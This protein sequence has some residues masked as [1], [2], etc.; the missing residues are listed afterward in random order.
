MLSIISVWGWHQVCFNVSIFKLY[1]IVV[2]KGI[3]K[4]IYLW[5]YLL[6]KKELYLIPKRS[7]QFYPVAHQRHPEKLTHSEEWLLT[8]S[9]SSHITLP[10]VSYFKSSQRK[11]CSGNSLMLSRKPSLNSRILIGARIMA[12]FKPNKQ[13]NIIIN[14]SLVGMS[15]MLTQE[16]KLICCANRVLIKAKQCYFQTQMEMLM[17]VYAVEHF[18]LY[19]FGSKFRIIT[20]Y[21]P[22][23]GIDKSQKSCT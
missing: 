15:A 3:L 6:V 1:E 19:L 20:D 2:V 18:C 12:Y 22:F 17:V 7:R 5:S 16:Y 14:S 8:S 11:M 13:T 4:C 23:I 9:Y 21:K 10:S